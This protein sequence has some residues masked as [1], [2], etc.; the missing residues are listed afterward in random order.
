MLTIKQIKQ[1]L[2]DSNLKQVAMKSG[3]H[4]ATV[5][6]FMRDQGKPTYETVELLSNYLEQEHAA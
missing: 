3:V 2:I 1:R 5:Y 6:R 4:P